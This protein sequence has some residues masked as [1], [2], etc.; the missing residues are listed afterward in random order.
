MMLP[1]ETKQLCHLFAEV[2]DYPSHSVPDTAAECVRR[3]EDSFP[4]IVAPMQ[5]FADFTQSQ[6]LGTLEELYAQ[7]FDITPATTLHVGY[8][9]FG[10][11]PKRSAL[12]VRLQEAYQC[13]HFSG[14]VELPDHLCVLLRFF[15]V[16]QEP[17]FVIPLLQECVLPVLEKM[18]KAFPKNKNGYAPVVRSLRL[19]LRQVYQRL[20]KEEGGTPH[21]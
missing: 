4:K 19:F 9:L 12:M 18:E 20:I 17:E 16:A 8:H 7:T 6:R 11:T 5:S 15:S 2:L 3:L 10:E 1:E 13:H 14:G 21:D